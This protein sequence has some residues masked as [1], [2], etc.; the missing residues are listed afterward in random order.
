[1]ERNVER[2]EIGLVAYSFRINK[3]PSIALLL[4]MSEIV[5]IPER[6]VV[7][8]YQLQFPLG[9]RPAFSCLVHINC[10]FYSL[11][12]SPSARHYNTMLSARGLPDFES[13][14]LV[15]FRKKLHAALPSERRDYLSEEIPDVLGI[16]FRGSS[17]R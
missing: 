6:G 15:S 4:E 7:H 1:M 11:C 3:K 13:R 5:A 8:E 10:N 9:V 12:Y 2:W 14:V 17:P 16:K